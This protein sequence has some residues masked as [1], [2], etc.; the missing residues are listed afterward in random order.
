MPPPS[1]RCV[2]TLAVSETSGRLPD[3]MAKQ[4][5]QYQE[6]AARKMKTL[7]MIAGGAVYAMVGLMLIVLILKMAMSIGGVYQDAMKGL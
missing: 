6:E 5:A 1:L 3:V 4:A 7:A 2:G